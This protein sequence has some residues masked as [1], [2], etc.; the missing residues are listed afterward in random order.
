MNKIAIVIPAYKSKYFEKTLN[1][2][3][4][5]N[6]K[7]FTLYIG[8]DHSPENLE[9]IV[10][11]FHSQMDIVYKKFDTNVGGKDLVAQ[12]NRCIEMTR[13]EEYIWLF[14]DDDVMP[15][16]CLLKVKDY[17]IR[18]NNICD[19]FHINSEVINNDGEN[20]TNRNR[21]INFP[22]QISCAEYIDFMFKGKDNT[23]GINF[24]VRKTTI[25]KNDGFV[26]FDLAWNADRASWL[27]FSYPTGILTVPDTFLE[28][29][30]SGENIS[31]L[32]NVKDIVVRK[33]NSRILYFKWLINFME[34]N[35]I[36][37]ITSR[38]IKIKYL[39]RIV[40]NDRLLS[41]R[42]KINYF[43]KY[44]RVLILSE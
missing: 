1:S 26:N 44:F 42:D 29:R 35:N 24:I 19:V 16:D 23:W 28:W 18:N 14:S 33:A 11:K 12:W 17:I 34:V 39:F 2:I 8:D 40:F 36:K 30:Y 10:S 6:C 27:K 31:A 43:F 21:I 38:F 5:Q 22:E 3:A 15:Y 4:N 37:D 7:N 9:E 20:I 13:D 25:L 32:K 41:L